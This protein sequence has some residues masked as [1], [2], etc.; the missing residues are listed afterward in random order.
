MIRIEVIREDSTLAR[1]IWQFEL[2][3]NSSHEAI[4]CQ[5]YKVQEKQTTRH[6]WKNIKQWNNRFNAYHQ[7]PNIELIIPDDVAM[8][9][10]TEIAKQIYRLPIKH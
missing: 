6:H 3:V 9:A 4:N 10:R 1:R 5:Y 7:H 2:I 8:E